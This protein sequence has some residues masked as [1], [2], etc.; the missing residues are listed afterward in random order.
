MNSDTLF[1]KTD[2]IRGFQCNVIDSDW[3]EK[4][5]GT[6]PASETLYVTLRDG[7]TAEFPAAGQ[8]LESGHLCSEGCVLTLPGGCLVLAEWHAKARCSRRVNPGAFIDKEGDP[9]SPDIQ[10]AAMQYDERGM[11]RRYVFPNG[12]TVQPRATATM[13]FHIINE[14]TDGAFTEHN[15]QEQP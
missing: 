5:P 9:Y 11:G 10:L 3:F 6:P 1:T 12:S 8:E 14:L 4:N 7:R 2:R 13:F 15:S